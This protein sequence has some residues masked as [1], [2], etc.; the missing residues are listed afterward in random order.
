MTFF[1]IC[2]FLN[3]IPTHVMIKCQLWC[4]IYYI[5]PTFNISRDVSTFSTVYHFLVVPQ[6]PNFT[7][8]LLK[9]HYAGGFSSTWQFTKKLFTIKIDK[10][11]GKLQ[12]LYGNTRNIYYLLPFLFIAMFTDSIISSNQLP[13]YCE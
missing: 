6:H 10:K 4:R 8:S 13:F 7:N 5:F 11:L 12:L 3:G 1:L 9:F 2:N